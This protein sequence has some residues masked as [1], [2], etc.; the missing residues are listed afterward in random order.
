M[1]EYLQYL[2]LLLEARKTRI[3]IINSIFPFR[4]LRQTAY[5]FVCLKSLA[6]SYQSMGWTSIIRGESLFRLLIAILSPA[7]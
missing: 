5:Q 3:C 6:I 7:K 4:R 1:V 2:F